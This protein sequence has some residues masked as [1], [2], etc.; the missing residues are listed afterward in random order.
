MT[1]D[2]FK[3]IFNSLEQDDED[4]S[5]ADIGR[6]HGKVDFKLQMDRYRQLYYYEM[7]ANDIEN[8]TLSDEDVQIFAKDG[9]KFNEDKNSFIKLI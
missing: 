9:W 7:T 2:N 1:F 5:L 6:V 4:F 8:S 3:N